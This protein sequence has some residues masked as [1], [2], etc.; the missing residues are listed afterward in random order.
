LRRNINLFIFKLK[1]WEW[2]MIHHFMILEILN[3][4]EIHILIYYSVRDLTKPKKRQKCS[5]VTTDRSPS[6]LYD[7]FRGGG[8]FKGCCAAL[9]KKWTRRAFK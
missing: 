9:Q 6:L 5:A 8:I 7:S 1:K 2:E 3:L 4:N